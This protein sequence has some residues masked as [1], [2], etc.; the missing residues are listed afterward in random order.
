MNVI[1]CKCLQQPML[2]RTCVLLGLKVTMQKYGD[3]TCRAKLLF[4]I[5]DLPAK[6]AL[7]NCVQYNGKY[8]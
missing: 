4:A 8:G 5:A 3:I 7:L 2:T 1:I 6:A